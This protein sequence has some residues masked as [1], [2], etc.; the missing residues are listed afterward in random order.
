MRPARILIVE[1][2]MIFALDLEQRLKSGG[3]ETCELTANGEKALENCER[4]QP[5][6]ALIDINLRGDLSGIE[7]AK[8]LRTRFSIPV[9][10]MTGYADVKTRQDAET[11]EPAGYFIK[12]FEIG[13]LIETIDSA[14]EENS[15]K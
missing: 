6:V 1:D 8:Q 7:T 2:E 10:F 5:D 9:I 14:V 3:Y 12:P 11:V 13:K 15:Q 4:Q